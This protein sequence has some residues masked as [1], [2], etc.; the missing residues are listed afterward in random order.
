MTLSKMP[1]PKE[2]NL[3]SFGEMLW[4]RI[5]LPSEE[6]GSFELF[7][8]SMVRDLQPMTPYEAVI[9]DQLIGLEWAIIQHRRMQ[10]AMLRKSMRE[11]TIDRL[12]ALRK[13]QHERAVRDALG[14]DDKG[15]GDEEDLCDEEDLE[16]EEGGGDEDGEREERAEDD[17]GCAADAACEKDAQGAEEEENEGLRQEPEPF[18]QGAAAH[19]AAV[20]LTL[21]DSQDPEEVAEADRLLAELATSRMDLMVEVWHRL[22]G[23][24]ARHEDIIRDHE[25]RRREVQR[26]LDAL[27]R[28]RPVE[29]EL[30][31]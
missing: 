1:D 4:R 23:Q 25:R 13:A 30:A 11:A 20:L 7:R 22:S 19:E 28:R 24:L 31:S 9:A 26:D 3:A 6:P 14:G 15:W 16:D 10:D 21:L 17:A 18:D 12:F 27:Q 5:A 29:G 8:D 2:F